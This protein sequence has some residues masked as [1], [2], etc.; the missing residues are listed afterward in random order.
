MPPVQE[1]AQRIRR[2]SKVVVSALAWCVTRAAI[3][4]LFWHAEAQI[5]GDLHHYEHALRQTSGARAALPEYPA[6]LLAVLRPLWILSGAHP[7]TFRHLFLGTMLA[8]DGAF[9]IVLTRQ[10]RKCDHWAAL[11]GWIAFGVALGPMIYARFDLL[12]A[13]AGA[14]A[15]MY[16]ARRPVVA[17]IALSV[18]FALK[19]WPIVL[20]PLLSSSRRQGTRLIGTA[21]AGVLMTTATCLAVVGVHRTFSPLRWQEHRGL[22]IE[23]LAAT[24]FMIARLADPGRWPITLGYGAFQ[25]TGPGT[26]AA[27]RVATLLT[28]AGAAVVA[29]LW[30]RT[31]LVRAEQP[32]AAAWLALTA[33]TIVVLTDKSFSPQYLI[34]IAAAAAAVVSL[35]PRSRAARA[36]LVAL[37]TIA[38]L[39]QLIFPVLYALIRPDAP[40]DT[41]A[42]ILVT[43]NGLLLAVG[44]ALVAYTA[45]RT[46]RPHRSASITS[47]SAAAVS[48]P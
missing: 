1:G 38:G 2:T 32:Q 27:L 6:A 34:W 40:S 8:V 13:V 14:L 29:W 11:T 15:I 36:L 12:P 9:T 21:T 25:V 48:Y 23:S 42:W 41:A 7:P 45:H 19:L 22:Q 39:S 37:I 26:E 4:G 46:R 35:E 17:G 43:R 33:T 16:A 47:P 20:A 30:R 24:P 18:G 28:A 44:A 31:W 5:N 10:A 3:V